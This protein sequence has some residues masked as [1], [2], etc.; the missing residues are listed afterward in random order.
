MKSKMDSIVFK[1]MTPLLIITM[2]VV[3]ATLVMT[4][5][6]LK[7]IVEN[8]FMTFQVHHLEKVYQLEMQNILLKIENSGLSMA[9]TKEMEQYVLSDDA[10]KGIMSPEMKKKLLDLK[11]LYKLDTIYVA[12]ANSKN[13]YDEH[14]FV[15]VVDTSNKESVWFNQTLQSKKHFLVNTD[16]DIT[17]KL[18]IWVDAVVGNVT[19]PSGLTGGGVDI[20]EIYQIALEDFTKNNADV[21]IL[22]GKQIIQASSNPS[23]ICN[24]ALGASNLSQEKIKALQNAK[25]QHHE[26][27]KY[28]THNDTRHLLLIKFQPLDWTIV[29]DFSKDEFLQPLD[30]VYNRII[31]GG[32]LL[33]LLM[34]LIG[35]WSFTYL[36]SRPLTQIAKVV[37]EYDYTS[38]FVTMDCKNMGSEIRMIYEAFQKS[39]LLMQE[40]LEKHKESE[41]LLK[42][43]INAA[44]DFIF[45]KD[46]NNVYIGV[47]SAYAKW[48]SK[49]LDEII[50]K[51]D[52]DLYPSNV[53]ID[54][55]QKDKYVMEHNQTLTVEEMF[56]N[57]NGTTLVLE[58]KKSPFF[59]VNGQVSGI[60]VV[61]RDITMI[62]EMENDLLILNKT[63]E[64]RVEDKT[65]ELQKTNE[66]LEEHIRDL[67]IL[68]I[69]L[70]K[71]KEAALQAAQAR[72]NFISGISHE[73]RT[74]LNAIINFT[75]QVIED[76]DEMLE[77]KE[78]QNENKNFLTRV[79][80]NSRHLLQLINDLLEFTKAE[81]GKMDYKLEEKNINAIVTMAYNNTS[82]L[83]NGT[84]IA[85]RLKLDE[86]LHIG[87]IDARR[88]LQILLNLLSNAI[89]F[90]DKGHIELRTYSEDE[91]IIVEIEDTGRGIAEDKQ[92]VIFEPFTQVKNTDSGT[93]LGLGLAK[94]MCE[95]MQIKILLTSVD[96]EGTTFRLMIKKSE[97]TQLVGGG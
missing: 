46:V 59:D 96:G 88:F 58:V 40:T 94:R 81:A 35:G 60:V 28:K 43:I 91:Y 39:S 86:G 25:E 70:T 48:K 13:Y 45:Y 4:Q 38:H 33:L 50:G 20:S 78:L 55:I 69:K 63:L 15:K 27:A 29:V 90:T 77:D 95:D 11:H 84:D 26:L 9:Q 79:L 34:M 41:E 71:A 76:F 37:Q 92:G 17:G 82:S 42:S 80:V 14:G 2:M 53:A 10:S 73:L 65:Q 23:V 22:N 21:T 49:S 54:H 61:A 56:Y 8:I 31:T 1:M 32:I 75:D 64:K 18:H 30:G 83:L 24:V 85:F 36:I 87:K 93:G 5:T 66:T 44:D 72:S 74:P 97:N 12:H 67:E 47:N 7:Q 68:N 16:S 57:N 52:R 3:G 89:K 51:T 6:Y 19:N 62:K